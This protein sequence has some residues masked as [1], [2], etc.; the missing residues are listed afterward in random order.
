M[1]TTRTARVV[2]GALPA[3]PRL[4]ALLARVAVDTGRDALSERK[5]FDLRLPSP[6]SFGVALD[7]DDGHLVGYARVVAPSPRALRGAPTMEL[8]VHPHWRG[9]VEDEL[10]AVVT[11]CLLQRGAR[12]V[13]WWLADDDQAVLARTWGFRPQRRLLELRRPV[14]GF[15]RRGVPAGVALRAYGGTAAE[16]AGI[17]ATNNAAFAGHPEQGGWDRAELS[18]R[19]SAPWFDAA[20]LLLARRRDRIVGYCWLKRHA[21][22]DLVELYAVAAHPAAGA[23]GLGSALVTRSF[24][25]AAERH[26]GATAQLFVDEAN[27]RARRLYDALG[28][29]A[30][31]HR[32]AVELDLRVTPTVA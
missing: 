2:D 22:T 21:R 26:P 13:T 30:H 4:D 20:D 31:D 25:V 19:L 10:L 7:D 28:F 27:V 18:R 8:A 23:A 17:L 9:R 1:A 15:P 14:D 6:G 5:Q 24:A 12:T 32:D 3:D 16:Q 29:A 11:V